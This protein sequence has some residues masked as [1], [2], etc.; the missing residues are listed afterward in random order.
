M[1]TSMSSSGLPSFGRPAP[2]LTA[3]GRSIPIRAAAF[4]VNQ[5][6]LGISSA[7]AWLAVIERISQDG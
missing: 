7:Q 5:A 4:E 3:S 1:G 2:R 6:G